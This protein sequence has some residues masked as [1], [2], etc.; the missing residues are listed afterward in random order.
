MQ[1][2]IAAR[3]LA[4]ARWCAARVV[5]AANTALAVVTRIAEAVLRAILRA[6]AAT[7]DVSLIPVE[8][9]IIATRRLADA[10]RAYAAQT[11]FIDHAR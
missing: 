3:A 1:S 6:G 5:K 2:V 9:T 8:H 10:R 11:V 4:S 7:V